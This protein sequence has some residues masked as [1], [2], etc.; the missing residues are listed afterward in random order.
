MCAQGMAC[1]LLHELLVVA[2]LTVLAWLHR[3][4]REAGNAAS[5]VLIIQGAT[6]CQDGGV[7]GCH[8]VVKAKAV[9]TGM[10]KYERRLRV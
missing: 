4:K 7:L 6:L 8:V 5:T 10:Y 3:D 2:V 1:Y 9:V